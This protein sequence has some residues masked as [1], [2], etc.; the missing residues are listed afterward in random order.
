MF[1]T[2]HMTEML[3]Q[4]ALI[5]T[6]IP[7]FRS[8]RLSALQKGMLIGLLAALYATIGWYL[9]PKDEVVVSAPHQEQV[10]T[11]EKILS[12][13]LLREIPGCEIGEGKLAQFVDIETGLAHI[14][15]ST[16]GGVISRFACKRQVDGKSGEL[17][18][19]QPLFGESNQIGD[20]LIAFAESTPLEYELVSHQRDMV[21]GKQQVGVHSVVFRATTP[22]ALIEKEFVIHNDLYKID[23]YMTINPLAGNVVR[24]RLFVHAPSLLEGLS[25]D[26]VKG[27]VLVDETRGSLEKHLPRDLDGR[28]WTKQALFGS[29]DRYFVS[30]LVKDSDR[31]ADRAYFDSNGP[32]SLVAIFEGPEVSK[33]RTW[34]LEFYVGPKQ[35]TAFEKVDT[36]LLS[37]LDY[38]WLKPICSFLMVV[39]QTIYRYVGNYGV[40]I[41]I[42][43]ILLK[44]LLLP[45]LI[46]SDRTQRKMS[47]LQRKLQ[48]LEKRYKDNPEALE[49]E[50]IE[51]MRKYGFSDMLLFGFLPQIAQALVFFGIN[52]MLS[53]SID[54]YRAPFFGW[55]HNLAA[56]DPYYI[57]PILA[58]I[59]FFLFMRRMHDVRQVVMA[60]M[61]GLLIIAI[62]ANLAAGVV[63]FVCCAAWF[64]MARVYI[65]RKEA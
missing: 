29:E 49:Q 23:L 33:E 9:G 34:K 10:V 5:I 45:L 55:I 19:F 64:D 22:V 44:L 28:L 6:L 26:V 24:P 53:V 61:M 38:G 13:P 16:Q 51:L 8:T 42:L 1:L 20:F 15:F 36:R 59:G 3:L 56:T 54:L 65:T 30:A 50:K 12:R 40:A 63:L 7:I 17:A 4:M 27:I 60:V 21:R 35:A 18:I 25:D 52:R 58:G 46:R 14:T 11:D 37:T 39:L 43:T 48:A 2:S 31:F 41:I 57:L 62:M 32:R 47:E